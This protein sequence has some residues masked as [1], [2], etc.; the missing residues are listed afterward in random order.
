MPS[1]LGLQSAIF[2]PLDSKNDSKTKDLVAAYEKLQS[3]LLSPVVTEHSTKVWTKR[4]LE[5]LCPR[6]SAAERKKSNPF[7]FYDYLASTKGAA[8]GQQP[9]QPSSTR[10]WESV[11]GAIARCKSSDKPIARS[12]T[13]EKHDEISRYVRQ[14]ANAR[15]SPSTTR[16]A[17]TRMH[18]AASEATP[19]AKREAH[20]RMPSSTR[21][22]EASVAPVVDA[23][24]AQRSAKKDE[25]LNLK[26][27]V[28]P[29][30]NGRWQSADSVEKKAVEKKDKVTQH[31]RMPSSCRGWETDAAAAAA[32]PSR[33]TSQKADE[34]HGSFSRLK[35]RMP[36]YWA[37]KHS[38]TQ[39]VEV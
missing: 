33:S 13:N 26:Y 25:A 14:V 1:P 16:D 9:R 21:E 10:E 38:R 37:P 24:K 11:G 17:G 7:D 32:M 27:A 39:S 35:I 3:P 31:K 8:P 19:K 34:S 4:E 18:R 2:F 6:K 23:I 12:V 5:L 15:E 20:K 28:R 29:S 22:W 30:G 36:G